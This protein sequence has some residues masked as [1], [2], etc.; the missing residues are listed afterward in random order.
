MFRYGFEKLSKEQGMKIRKKQSFI[1]KQ[2]VIFLEENINIKDELY[3]KLRLPDGQE[4]R[5]SVPVL[6]Y[7]KYSAG[8]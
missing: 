2:L 5:F 4:I 6:K 7:W 8:I 1:A 3:F